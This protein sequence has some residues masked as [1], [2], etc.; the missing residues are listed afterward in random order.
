MR[1]ATSGTYG[2]TYNNNISV[3][4]PATDTDYHAYIEGGAGIVFSGYID[5]T[6]G[7]LIVTIPNTAY[8]DLGD[9]TWSDAA[10]GNVAS[11]NNIA[12]IAKK[13]A[14]N[15]NVFN[16][17]CTKYKPYSRVGISNNQIC[18]QAN[19]NVVICDANIAGMT[20]EQVKSYVSGTKLAFEVETPQIY[21]LTPTVIKT[22]LGI[23]NI[24]ADTGDI[25]VIYHHELSAR[26]IYFNN[27]GTDLTATNVEAAIKELLGRISGT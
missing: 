17:L 22:L 1:I 8:V 11:S 18:I 13:P 2:N 23:N 7:E 9:F 19:G 16:G 4:F 21:Q 5:V 6:T 24:F 3:N 12:T 10:Q 25:D 14:T 27:A 15:N 26:Y 20:A